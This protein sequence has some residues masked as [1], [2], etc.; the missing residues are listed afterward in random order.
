MIYDE[1]EKWD[2]AYSYYKKSLEEHYKTNKTSKEKVMAGLYKDEDLGA[3]YFNL[4]RVLIKLGR[5]GESKTNMVLAA[6]CGNK[7]AIEGCERFSLNYNTK[8]NPTPVRNKG[9]R[10]R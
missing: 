1:Q 2:D 7:T 3:T 8:T 9:N 10:R 6:K 5:E 4:C